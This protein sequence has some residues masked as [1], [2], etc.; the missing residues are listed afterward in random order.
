MS[1][2]ALASR[3][4]E[5]TV[6]LAEL[7]ERIGDAVSTQVLRQLEP[8]LRQGLVRVAVVGVT[9]SGKST[10]VNALVQRLVLPEN[11]SVSSPIPV[12]LG[13]HPGPDAIARVYRTQDGKTVTESCDSETFRSRYCYNLRDIQDKDR[14]RYNSVSFSTLQLN[15][16][17]LE[18][19]LTL[20]D[21]LGI[22][23]TAVDS[24]KTIR[25]LDEGVDAVIFVTRNSKLNLEEM[26]FLYRHVLGRPAADDPSPLQPNP[27]PVAPENLIFV[28]NNFYGV[29]NRTE[30]AERIRAFYRDSGLSLNGDAIDALAEENCFYI[31]AYHGR[32]GSLGPYPYARCAPEGSSP[33]ELEML[34]RREAIEQKEFSGS[35]PL[36]LWESS[37]IDELTA[38]V[39]TLGKRL[40]YGSGAVSVRRITELLGVIDGVIQSVDRRNTLH[41]DSIQQLRS[42]RTYLLEMKQDDQVDQSKLEA[43]MTDRCGAYTRS[44]RRLLEGLLPKLKKDC[45]EKAGRRQMSAGFRKHYPAY[46]KMKKEEQL[47]YL[48]GLLPELNKFIYNHCCEQLQDALKTG[49]TDDFQT[50]LLVMGETRELIRHQAI[51]FNARI[52]RLRKAGGEALG[53]YFPQ[54]LAVDQLFETLEQD[55]VERIQQ[56][57]ADA[58]ITGGKD[59][60]QKLEPY[61]KQCRLDFFQ[62]VWAFLK[63]DAGPEMLWDNVRKKLFVPLAE[64]IVTHMPEHTGSAIYDKTAE[65]FH[66]TTVEICRAH[67]SLFVSLEMGISGLEKEISAAGVHAE[68]NTADARELK[69]ICEEIKQDI[70]TIQYRLQHG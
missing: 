12:W 46:R 41:Y 8:R 13:H 48:N 60:E 42:L 3:L 7:T 11:P 61:V 62:N 28:N 64:H 1:E 26:R 15:A 56:I 68:R 59:F 54:P 25:V 50:P 57:I 51:L 43:A 4:A 30:F 69:Q 35:D 66:L 24:R 9:G 67:M 45:A 52:E 55:L 38:A 53:L 36:Q 37:G 47:A 20:I 14:S 39:R 58:C 44:F 32:L 70:L 29:P 16:P 6:R 34:K 18:N 10:M 2:I 19:D 31:N 33:V 27:R 21:T 49:G 17:V 23:A 40:C 5:H 65:A 22:S 63:P